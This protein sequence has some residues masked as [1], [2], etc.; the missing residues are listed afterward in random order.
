MPMA[1][2]D[3]VAAAPTANRTTW[4]SSVKK[5]RAPVCVAPVDTLG[6]PEAVNCRSVD[7]PAAAA[8]A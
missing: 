3:E 4:V 8:K 1:L 6:V 2:E 7:V 5:N